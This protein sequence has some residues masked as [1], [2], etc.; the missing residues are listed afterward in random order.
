MKASKFIP[1]AVLALIVAILLVLYLPP[2]LRYF[3]FR[4]ALNDMVRLVKEGDPV[5]AAKYAEDVDYEDLIELIET[6]VPPDYHE[7]LVALNVS[8]VTW[9]GECYN[10]RLVAR[11]QG[12][13]YSGI[14]QA[15]MKWRRTEQGWR[16]SLRDTLVAEGYPEGRFVSLEYYLGSSELFRH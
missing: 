11:F 10:V 9:D 4:G 12:Q 7:D 13:R 14:G 2:T 15:K 8:S 16:F 6:R 5:A 1:L 3:S